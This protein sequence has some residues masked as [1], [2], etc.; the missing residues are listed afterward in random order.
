MSKDSALVSAVVKSFYG[1]KLSL[2][3]DNF[4]SWH[5]AWIHH[6]ALQGWNP[7]WLE[8]NSEPIDFANVVE[9]R[10][11]ARLRCRAALMLLGT[12]D[13]TAYTL[14]LKRVQKDNPQAIFQK[15]ATRHKLG[16][17]RSR[18]DLQKKL[19]DATMVGTGI[20]L[21]QHGELVSQYFH[22]LVDMHS[23]PPTL[24]V[25]E[26]YLTGLLP[27]FD[28]VAVPHLQHLR[29]ARR[30][31]GPAMTH[32]LDDMI[33]RIE[34]H[35]DSMGDR[36]LH[37]LKDKVHRTNLSSSSTANAGGQ[38]GAPPRLCDN[39][40]TGTC[41]DGDRCPLRHTKA[42]PAPPGSDPKYADRWCDRCQVHGHSR[43]YSKCPKKPPGELRPPRNRPDMPKKKEIK[44]FFTALE[45]K[46]TVEPEVL[47]ECQKILF[48][49]PVGD[50]HAEQEGTQCPTEVRTATGG[51]FRCTADPV[52]VRI[53]SSTTPAR[54]DKQ[55]PPA[56]AGPSAGLPQCYWD[57]G[58]MKT[59][60]C[61]RRNMA[62]LQ[63]IKNTWVKL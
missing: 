59:S 62:Q 34:A 16:N 19:A 57:S 14:L 31:I 11:H 2:S 9:E 61:T 32:I 52:G 10:E 53:L 20:T 4:D 54:D 60:S 47:A 58:A 41:A 7:A 48:R 13:N 1:P 25:L 33:D 45:K 46:G 23:T 44:Q 3:A 12:I 42:P 35:A 36:D 24:D 15:L 49:A 30:G 39:F 18:K 38:P 37:S 22:A 56:P 63:V 28:F 29:N 8:Q 21:R 17:P 55:P 51:M 26:N 43:F 40:Q 6:G 50:G 5:D 27:A